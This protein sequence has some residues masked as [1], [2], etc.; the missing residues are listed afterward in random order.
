[1]KKRKIAARFL[2]FLIVVTIWYWLDYRGMF[3]RI[4][5][6]VRDSIPVQSEEDIVMYAAFTNANNMPWSRAYHFILRED[7]VMLIAHGYRRTT[8]VNRRDF[9]RKRRGGV[10]RE[11]QL[12]DEEFQRLIDLANELPPG[13]HPT[14]EGGWLGGYTTILYYNGYFY[15]FGPDLELEVF[16]RLHNEIVAVTS[17]DPMNYIW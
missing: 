10:S 7:G 6:F 16:R 9:I 8:D 1:M 11:I 4:E 13:G 12:S 15:D 17:I 2:L 3:F 14:Q 5:T